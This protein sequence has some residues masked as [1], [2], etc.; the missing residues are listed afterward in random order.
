MKQVP[1]FDLFIDDDLVCYR[2]KMNSKSVRSDRLSQAPII[3][4]GKG[5]LI[6]PC[7]N[8]ENK[9]VNLFY[10]RAVALAFIPNPEGKPTVDHIDRNPLNCTVSNLR[11]A[12]YCEQN[13]NTSRAD[14]SVE[15]FGVHSTD[16]SYSK[17]SSSAYFKEHKDAV[18]LRHREYYNKNKEAILARHAAYREANR[19]TINERRR[20]SRRRAK[21]QSNA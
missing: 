20:M 17:I 1:G 21:E 16:S 9:P 5:Y 8:D 10:H 13:R 2:Y 4:D 6:V 15:R 7:R 12:D 3:S 11:W 14:R 19:D 18:L